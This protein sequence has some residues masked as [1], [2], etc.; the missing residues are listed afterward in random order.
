MSSG[1]GRG[2][3]PGGVV[4][5]LGRLSLMV[6]FGFGA[7]LMIGV[8]FEEPELLAGHLRGESQAVELPS[9]EPVLATAE[10]EVTDATGDGRSN[11][12]AQAEASVEQ[13][14]PQVAASAAIRAAKAPSPPSPPST[15]PR[16]RVTPVA[17]RDRSRPWAIQV[18]A[19]AKEAAARKLSQALEGKGYTAQV[20]A[21][22]SPDGRWRVRVQPIAG[23]DAAREMAA[24][25]KR[26]ERLPTW[27]LPMEG[28]SSR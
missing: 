15:A 3:R 18:G 28:S 2:L 26:E 19:F 9:V 22:G 14:L 20:L 5:A 16:S 24:E 4:R 17:R 25:L 12:V 11:R 7:G 23:E 8:L 21:A 6:V 1:T 27:V 13:R 10:R